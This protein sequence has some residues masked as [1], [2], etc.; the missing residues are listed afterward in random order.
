ME[1]FKEELKIQKASESVQRIDEDNATNQNLMDFLD[2]DD[3][4]QDS[5]SPL[6]TIT[7]TTST[8]SK[9]NI[10][11]YNAIH[12]DD[13]YYS[14]TIGDHCTEEDPLDNDILGIYTVSTTAAIAT[15]SS[16]SAVQSNIA[17]VDLL[18]MMATVHMEEKSIS[19]LSLQSHFILRHSTILI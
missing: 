2:Q 1:Q 17:Q 7:T 12:D 16:C 15:G 13:H 18:S 11:P 14:S 19:I 5:M 3:D 10:L 8:L 6:K 4:R 9:T